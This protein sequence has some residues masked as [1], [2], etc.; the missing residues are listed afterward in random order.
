MRQS[1]RGAALLTL[2]SVLAFGL[3]PSLGGVARATSF[4]STVEQALTFRR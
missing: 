3:L 4:L 2:S 1:S